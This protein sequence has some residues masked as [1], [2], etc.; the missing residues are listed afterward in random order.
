[1][2][3]QVLVRR[4][5][6]VDYRQSWSAMK[7]FTELRHS[8]TADEIWLLQHLP[9]FTQGMRD[10]A[11]PAIST[12]PVV[13][14]DRGGLIT[15]HGPGQFIAYILMDLK[16]RGWGIRRLVESL[17][18]TI[19]ELLAGLNIDAARMPDAPGVYVEQSKVAS[20][21][22]RVR[23]GASYHGL[24]LNVDMDLTPFDM[25]DPC[26][27]PELTMTQLKDLGVVMSQNILFDL[28]QAQL[29]KQLGYESVLAVQSELAY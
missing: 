15:Y 22:L 1:M 8:E 7:K 3:N 5:G 10:Y 14:S 11:A 28:I 17:E 18:Q 21:G 20:L 19:I 16:R 12:I 29:L 27:F 13:N 4:L 26:G 25:I 2:I 24:S 9:V 6:I 23:R